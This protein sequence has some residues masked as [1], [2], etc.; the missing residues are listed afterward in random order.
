M[1]IKL[2]R[3]YS[4]FEQH[5]SVRLMPPKKDIPNFPEPLSEL[6]LFNGAPPAKTD[7]PPLA[8]KKLLQ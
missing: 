8:D 5:N 4:I 1:Q 7:K 3:I 2:N 6:E